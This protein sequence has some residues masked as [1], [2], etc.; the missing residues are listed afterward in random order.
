MIDFSTG[1]SFSDILTGML[2][3]VDDSLDK[4]EGS[5]IYTAL[6]PVA[7]Y[8]EGLALDLAQMQSASYVGTATGT[9]LD[10]YVANRGITRVAATP[11]VRQGIFDAVIPS[12]SVFKTVNGAD[13]VLFTSGDLI[14]SSGGVW[15]YK[16]TCQTAGEIGN[17]Y[18][19]QIIP[20]TAIAGLTTATIGE[21]ITM[22]TDEETDEALRARFF[23]SLG[24]APY[25]GNISE[26]RQAILAVPGVGGVQIYP[27]NT[28]QGG[29]T[30]LCSIIDDDYAPAA[31]AL[32]STVQQAI[33]P[34]D[35]GQNTPSQNG[36]G[37]API[38]AAVTITAPSQLT[39][40]ISFTASFATGITNGAT[41]YHDDI[42]NAINEY[43]TSVAKTWGDAVQN[44]RI[45]YSVIIY[46]ARVVY[47]ILTVP[48]VVNVSDL[49]INGQSSDL[50]LT[51]TSALQ[52]IPTLGTVTI[53]D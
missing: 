7:W 44:N 29:G 15:V 16:M 37:I 32:V 28:Y 6:A 2:E 20:V 51:E 30:V 40:N 10:Y 12:G 34:P 31:P 14:S 1:Y 17:S 23:A 49:L 52:Q 48:E 5:L 35:N 8:L 4:R 19:G 39:V 22:G 3:Q 46:A 36:Y 21:I 18:T 50:V 33:C 47:A 25:G 26:Y 53:N 13:S 41:T 43:I 27:A 38:G 45:S 24:S 11:A 9:D 42:V